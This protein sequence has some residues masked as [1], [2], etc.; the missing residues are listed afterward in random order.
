M[1]K[2]ISYETGLVTESKTTARLR[3]EQEATYVKM[4]VDDLVAILELPVE[5]SGLLYELVQRIDDD[6]TLTLRSTTKKEIA[7]RLQMTI[8]TFYNYL[9]TLV[10]V[11][12]LKR[13]E[14]GQFEANPYLLPVAS[15]R[16]SVNN[17]I[18]QVEFSECLSHIYLLE[19]ER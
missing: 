2:K 16:Q 4:Y 19:R 18:N 17:L 1:K 9:T 8:G 5:I 15:G 10:K 14:R 13:I 7:D 11:G 3:L 6:G 12:V